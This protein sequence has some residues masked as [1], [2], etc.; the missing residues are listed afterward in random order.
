MTNLPEAIAGEAVSVPAAVAWVTIAYLL[1]SIPF[2]LL[3]GRAYGVDIRKTGSGNVGATNLARV[4]GRR[5][6]ITAFVLD[7]L[8][9]L[10]PVLAVG[11]LPGRLPSSSGILVEHA[12]IGCALAA[13]L[14]HVFPVYLSFRGGKGVATSFG[15]LTGLTP[16]AALAAGVVWLA[17]FTVT[18]TVSIA[19]IAAALVFPVA[20]LIV[21]R[22]APPL[23]AVPMDCLAASVAALIV[24][25]HRSN[26]R[27]LLKREEGRF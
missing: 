14:G 13:V 8:K 25:R 9:G 11:F 24:I 19:S 23:V 18:R 5:L 22:A 26:I 15:A 20:T 6:G 10:L 17:L 27:R 4:L 12:Q 3:I 7:F 21:F 1:G 16:T 2:A